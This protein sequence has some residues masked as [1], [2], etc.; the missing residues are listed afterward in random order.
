MTERGM[1]RNSRVVERQGV[2]RRS[3]NRLNEKSLT[4]EL[5]GQPR[6]FGCLD[7]GSSW[8]SVIFQRVELFVGGCGQA[9]VREVR[10]VLPIALENR[11]VHMSGECF[12]GV[13]KGIGPDPR[14]R[15]VALNFTAKEVQ[16][17]P[18]EVVLPDDDIVM[19]P[20]VVCGFEP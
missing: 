20:L 7:I 10:S 3:S 17:V 9:G 13:P 11:T 6:V 19:A 2:R 8:N 16:I 15:R 1:F 14:P 5:D 18:N 12:G 4:R